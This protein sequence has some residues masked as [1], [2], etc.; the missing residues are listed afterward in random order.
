MLKS[1]HIKGYRGIDG[2]K[3][4][5]MQRF[6]LLI[7]L[8]NSGKSSLIEAILIHCSPVNFLTLLDIISNR[9]GGFRSNSPYLLEKLK[10]LVTDPDERQELEM[11]MEGQIENNQRW[12]NFHLKLGGASLF[13]SL[14]AHPGQFPQDQSTEEGLLLGL[15]KLGFRSTLQK[16]PVTT[17]MNFT[18]KGPVNFPPTPIRNDVAAVL[19]TWQSF[20]PNETAKYT[21]SVK[22]G[23]HKICLEMIRNIEPQIIDISLLTTADGTPELYV[24]HQQLGWTPLTNLGRGISRMY[25]VAISLAQCKKGILLIDELENAIHISALELFVNWLTKIARMNEFDIQIFAT[26]HSLECIDAVLGSEV[27]RNGELCLYKVD[28]K[29]GHGSAK[30]VDKSDLKSAREEFG[31]DLRLD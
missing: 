22:S 3:I 16:Q 11:S 8:N 24:E 21:A 4:E 18:A 17:T 19:V 10:W 20:P 14:Q 15:A 9:H 13:P 28:S 12:T 29:D 23:H 27:G 6:N 25:E 30:R 2:L 5:G 1:L 7:G 31:I 26:T